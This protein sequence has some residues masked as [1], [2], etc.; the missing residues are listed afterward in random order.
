MMRGKWDLEVVLKHKDLEL[1]IVMLEVLG[2]VIEDADLLNGLEEFIGWNWQLWFEE[3]KPE[4][5]GVEGG[6]QEITDVL[7]LV[8]VDHVLEVHEVKVVG[9]RVQDRKAGIVHVLLPK[10]FDFT[11]H[12]GE[13]RL[14]GDH[15]VLQV[16]LVNGSRFAFQE[17]GDGFDARLT[18]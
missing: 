16:V 14:K 1:V 11:L 6:L 13:G 10:S 17:L 9:P 15:R 7:H 18:L 3:G 8:L 12:E 2:G 4:D 5:L